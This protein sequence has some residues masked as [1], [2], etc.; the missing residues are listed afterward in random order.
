MTEFYG[1][2]R[3]IVV[4]LPWNKIHCKRSQPHHELGPR[5]QNQARANQKKGLIDCI[6]W[7]NNFW[8]GLFF[9]SEHV[10]ESSIFAEEN[11]DDFL[12]KPGTKP[13]CSDSHVV[14]KL[15]GADR[16]QK[17]TGDLDWTEFNQYQHV[18]R[19]FWGF[20]VRHLNFMILAS[21]PMH[22]VAWGVDDKTSMASHSSKLTRPGVSFREFPGRFPP[23]FRWPQTMGFSHIF[24]KSTMAMEDL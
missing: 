20:G 12:R 6:S 16:F 3:G 10:Q 15:R 5:A 17:P 7:A 9:C 13:P 24:Q 23:Y 21:K 11:R 1:C 2:S 14:W 22:D 8:I 4:G 18:V 19:W